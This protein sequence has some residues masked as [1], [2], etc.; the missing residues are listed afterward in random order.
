MT[1]FQSSTTEITSAQE[2]Y[3]D[4]QQERKSEYRKGGY[5]PVTE[6]ELYNSRYRVVKKLGWGYF[7][8]VWLCWDQYATASRHDV[9]HSHFG[10]SG[11]LNFKALKI[12]KSAQH[13]REAAQDEITLLT[14][15]RDGDRMF[16]CLSLS[17]K[18]K[19]VGFILC[20]VLVPPLLQKTVVFVCLCLIL[21][22]A[23]GQ[24]ILCPFSR[25]EIYAYN[26]APVCVW[27]SSVEG[28]KHLKRPHNE[29]EFLTFT[30]FIN[31]ESF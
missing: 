9:A 31:F 10:C 8:T 3:S 6:G 4:T 14:Q 7:S 24:S 1:E 17:L 29:G 5:H 22:Y 30:N 23:F 27:V 19:L 18:G 13:Y 26:C 15:I 20:L 16:V 2:D 28:L 21:Q 12:Q 11:E 25:V